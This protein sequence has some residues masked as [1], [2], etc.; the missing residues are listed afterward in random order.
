MELCKSTL[1]A[2]LKAGPLP[3]EERW[4]VLRGVLQVSVGGGWGFLGGVRVRVRVRAS[5]S[6]MDEVQ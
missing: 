1:A 2:A 6:K 4:H 5:A 3:E